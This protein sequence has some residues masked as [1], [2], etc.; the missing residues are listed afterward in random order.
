VRPIADAGHKTVL[1]GIEMNV[2]DMTGKV[3]FVANCVL[4]KPTLPKRVFA[5]CMPRDGDPGPDCMTAEIPFNPR[6]GRFVRNTNTIQQRLSR[7]QVM[8]SPGVAGSVAGNGTPPRDRPCISHFQS[9]GPPSDS[10]AG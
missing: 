5:I 7:R 6:N 8:R 1:D 3:V 2:I 4:P 9:Q 10:S